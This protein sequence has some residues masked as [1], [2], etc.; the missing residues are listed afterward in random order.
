MWHIPVILLVLLCCCAPAHAHPA[1][2]SYMRV[3]VERQK[4]EFRLTFNLLTLMRFAQIDANHDRRIDQAEIHAATPTLLSYLRAHVLVSFN[5]MDGELGAAQKIE[6]VWPAEGG[7]PSA[8]EPDYGA[9]YLD[10]TFVNDCK[11]LVEDFW[12]GFE[13]FGQTGALHTIEAT[14]EQDDLR[15]QVPF[16]EAEPEYTY[17]TGFA[18]EQLFQPPAEAGPAAAATLT[19]WPWF[20][21]AAG[22]AVV[23]IWMVLCRRR[24][25]PVK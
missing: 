14:F 9:R 22:G 3:R 1:D 8:A 19:P 15:L 25:R 24:Q 17:D 7:M 11:P 23:S 20:A 13:I 5:G 6:C 16:S 21:A 4:V 10:I 2:I 18:T 12:I